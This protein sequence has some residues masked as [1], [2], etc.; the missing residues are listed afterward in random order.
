[1]GRAGVPSAALPR[2]LVNAAVALPAVLGLR[3]VEMMTTR[4]SIIPGS[5]ASKLAK[6]GCGE[7]TFGH[8][9]RLCCR[10]LS[11]IHQYHCV[12][13]HANALISAEVPSQTTPSPNVVKS[14]CLKCG[15]VKKSGKRSCC[16]R[17]GAW[18]KNCGN[19]G[20]A[21]FDHTWVD[22]IEAC[23]DA[24]SSPNSPMQVELHKE[25]VI[26]DQ[27]NISEPRNTVQQQKDMYHLN[28]MATRRR[29]NGMRNTCIIVSKDYVGFAKAVGFMHVLCI[30]LYS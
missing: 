26:D 20:D 7:D 10:C 25:G 19:D 2:N 13:Y 3:S 30:V 14:G 21:H 29:S 18:F 23:K 8:A 1:M 9:V 6:V 17:G 4:S 28:S 15:Y 24:T 27:M 11:C 5:R 12:S 22:G 16:A